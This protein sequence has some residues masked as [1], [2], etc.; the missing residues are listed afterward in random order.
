MDK[1]LEEPAKIIREYISFDGNGINAS[2]EKASAQSILQ[3]KGTAALWQR[4][5]SSNFAYLA[6]EVGMGKTRQAMAVIA[7]QILKKPDSRIVIICPGRP[8]QEQWASE[9]NK[10][11]ND[12]FIR[13]DGTLKSPFNSNDTLKLKLHERLN[14]FAKALLLDDDKLHLLRYSSF[15]RPIGFGNTKNNIQ[16]AKEYIKSTY[17]KHLKN[18]GINSLSS[19]EEKYINNAKLNNDDERSLLTYTLN[20]EYAKRFATLVR[21]EARPIDLIICDEAQ[22]LR[23]TENS[24]NTNINASIGQL[25]TKWL[26]LSATPLHNG[27]NDIKSLD[28]YLCNHDKTDNKVCTHQ[29]CSLITAKLEGIG[30]D[31]KD[32]VDVMSEF[33]VRRPRKYSDKNNEQYHKASYRDFKSSPVYASNDAF[34]SIVTSLVQKKLVEALAGQNNRFRQGECSSFE[35]LASSVGKRFYIDSDGN[36]KSE[37]EYESTGAR[38]TNKDNDDSPDRTAI[39]HLNKSLRT[40]LSSIKAIENKDPKQIMLPHAKIYEVAKTL[41]DKCIINAPNHKSLVFVRRLDTVEEL[42][43]LVQQKFQDEVDRR[44]DLW[45]NYFKI[46]P[47]QLKSNKKLSSLEKFWSQK[48]TEEPIDNSDEETAKEDTGSAIKQAET[49]PYFQAVLAKSGNQAEN[50]ILHSFSSRLLQNT[51]INKSPLQFLAPYNKDDIDGQTK[52]SQQWTQLLNNIYSED[53]TPPWLLDNKHVEK[54]LVLKRAILQSMRRSDFLVDLYI[55]HN[56]FELESEVDLGD[57]LLYILEQAKNNYFNDKF[58]DLNIY[59]NNWRK[60]LQNWCE[61]FDLIYD[62]CFQS[63]N[64]SNFT[65]A[66]NTMNDKFLRMGPILGR[67][68]R[69]QNVHAVTQFKMP[70]Y[71]N[72]LICTDVLKEGVDMHLYCDDVIHYGVAWTSGDLEQRIGRV[73]R[74]KSLIH[75]NISEYKGEIRNDAPKLNVNFPYLSGTLDQHQVLRVMKEKHNSDLRMD[76]GKR[77]NEVKEI[78]IDQ[79]HEYTNNTPN[80]ATA[81]KAK[82]YYPQHK[83]TNNYNNDDYSI[84]NIILEEQ[85]NNFADKLSNV[86]PDTNANLYLFNNTEFS[87]RISIKGSSENEIDFEKTTSQWVRIKEGRKFI[88]REYHSTIIPSSI[89]TEELNKSIIRLNKITS[90]EPHSLK[91]A[92]FAPSFHFSPKWNTLSKTYTHV[93]PF[94]QTN[95]RQQTVLLEQLGDE[96]FVRSPIIHTEEL[97]DDNEYY[98]IISGIN[99]NRKFAYAIEQNNIIWLCCRITCA[100]IFN[101]KFEYITE[102]LSQTADRLQLLYTAQD[103]EH[104]NYLS[105][106]NLQSLIPKNHSDVEIAHNITHLTSYSENIRQW[107]ELIFQSTVQAMTINIEV[108]ENTLHKII[109]QCT[110]DIQK[111]GMIH[112]EM[113][114]DT[115]LR[116]RLSA[117]LEFNV[118]K[119]E[120]IPTLQGSRIVWQLAVSTTNRGQARKLKF[121]NR[122]LLP[123]NDPEGWNNI[124]GIKFTL[125]TYKKEKERSLVLYHKPDAIDGRFNYFIESWANILPMIKE[126]NFQKTLCFKQ[127]EELFM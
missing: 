11:I 74:V 37:Q 91:T 81:L 40:A 29:D 42:V 52:I 22:Y 48:I 71:P 5:L 127:F 84:N 102:K 38:Y 95:N 78:S 57:K 34:A 67:S 76:F 24:R 116:F 89:S 120:D 2:N 88:W 33:L 117:D 98:T 92:S 20:K 60:R 87:I 13:T 53:I 72:I 44:I 59:F 69:M 99:N 12:C 66:L 110:A 9:W 86:T 73:D 19:K 119:H 126:G 64:T 15:S 45:K 80:S 101:N 79:L 109:K 83:I 10:F 26:F 31:K 75:R 58:N 49:L 43:V 123:H 93:A 47:N 100:N 28:T 14:E 90:L 54:V 77:E 30:Y 6:D 32:V 63:G 25:D 97:N 1:H 96:I 115:K 112:I 36:K 27:P 62:K 4:L 104:W 61:N 85:I 46:T 118:N 41:S 55:M 18:I 105:P 68:G 39:D 114:I 7:M 125:H 70:C 56:F 65:D 94:E 121:Y 17:E 16:D 51:S 111:N 23:H 106:P 103:K 124:N 35:S 50:G 108:E 3:S 82:D 113:P 21:K 8:L 107:F 122:D